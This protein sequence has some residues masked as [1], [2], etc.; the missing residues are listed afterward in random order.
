MRNF[1]CDEQGQ[2]VVEYVLAVLFAVSVVGIIATT[3][4]KSILGLWQFIAKDVSAAC[5]GCPPD[6]NVRFH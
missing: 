4:R 3:F 2:A 5:P 6:P 1:F